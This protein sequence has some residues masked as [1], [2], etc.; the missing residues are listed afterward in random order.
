MS[1]FEFT[2]VGLETAQC[3]GK[4]QE[5]RVVSHSHVQRLKREMLKSFDLFPAITVNK[6]TNNIIDGQHRNEAYIGLMKDNLLPAEAKLKV[7]YVDVA[8]D[9]EILR[10]CDA[11]QN[12][13]NWG[14]DDFIARY[15]KNGNESYVTLE[16]WC[17]EHSLCVENKKNKRIPKYRYGAAILKGT[18]CSGTLKTGD[19]TV[20][21]E[22]IAEANVKHTEMLAIIEALG[23]KGQGAW[24]ESLATTWS[25]YRL[26]HSFK[27][28]MS[29][30]K[31]NKKKYMKWPKENQDDWKK[32]FDE[33][34]SQLDLAVVASIKNAA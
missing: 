9:D 2:T 27:D 30:I 25:K 31:K 28:W 5:N 17:L 23:M 33:I 11:N 10:I 7:M 12:S 19:F 16:K 26:L 22:E 24:I 29:R 20:T 18:S 34:H 6:K 4:N 32:I 1:N 14:V 13:K 15:V 3:F 8:P 21:E